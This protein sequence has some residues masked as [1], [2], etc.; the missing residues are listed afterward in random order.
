MNHYE[1]EIEIVKGNAGKLRKEGDK[2]VRPDDYEKQGLK[3]DELYDDYETYYN[4]SLI[5]AG[6]AAAMWLYGITD[7]YVFAKDEIKRISTDRSADD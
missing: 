1:F 5:A 3:D 7:A 6:V 2:I 4:G